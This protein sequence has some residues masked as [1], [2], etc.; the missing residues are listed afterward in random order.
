MKQEEIMRIPGE[1]GKVIRVIRMKRKRW[2]TAAMLGALMLITG[3]VPPRL[4][5]FAGESQDSSQE[6]S[7]ERRVGKEC[8]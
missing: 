7:E 3:I 2:R 4:E 5:V 6:R 8:T 1:K